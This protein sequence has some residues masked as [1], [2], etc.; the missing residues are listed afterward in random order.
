MKTFKQFNE[1]LF[2]FLPKGKLQTDLQR[3]SKE[4]KID[5][6]SIVNRPYVNPDKPV[7]PNLKDPMPNREKYGLP[8]RELKYVFPRYSGGL[9]V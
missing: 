4:S 9:E 7:K 5:P 6:K 2:D 3:G 1:G 8:P